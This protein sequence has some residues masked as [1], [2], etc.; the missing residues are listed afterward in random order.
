MTHE[1]INNRLMQKIILPPSI[2]QNL[3]VLRKVGVMCILL[4]NFSFMYTK[5][6]MHS[7]KKKK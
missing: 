5:R 3:R 2:F 4:L 6:I 1:I 7:R